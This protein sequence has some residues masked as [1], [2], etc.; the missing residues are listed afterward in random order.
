MEVTIAL[1]C[2]SGDG[3]ENSNMQLP[4][5]PRRPSH[6]LLA[7]VREDIEDDVDSLRGKNRNWRRIWRL[8]WDTG[9]VCHL[10]R[11]G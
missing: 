4:C 7:S 8:D 6:Q 2:V 5:I 9:E 3:R 11:G 1:R 10:R